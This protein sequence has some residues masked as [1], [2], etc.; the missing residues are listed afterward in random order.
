MTETTPFKKL[1]TASALLAAAVTAAPAF[2]ADGDSYTIATS[3]DFPPLSYRDSEDTSKIIGFEMDMIEAMSEHGG[4][5]YELKTSA[6]N[7]LLPSLKSGRVDM[8]VSDIYNTAERRKSVD[9]INYIENGFA[10]MVRAEDADS[11]TSYDDMCGKNIGILTG[12]A[13]E[14]DAVTAASEK[15]CESQGK[16]AIQ[17][18]SYPSVAQEIPQLANGRLSGILETLTT[19]A[20]AQS[21]NEG[22][23]EIA[24][25]DPN[26][27][28]VGIALRKNSEFA[29]DI[30]QDMA[31]YMSSGKADENAKKWDI[32]VEAL[33]KNDSE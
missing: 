9:F 32:P 31:W 33:I 14:M 18:K 2:A 22:K 29:D 3:A 10:V 17:P 15:H 27:T 25:R 5:D 13:P 11:L 7:G 21:Q 20:Y 26:T 6:F 16:P 30:K 28:K 19:L 12:S 1:M 8:V 23:F 4:W 24:F